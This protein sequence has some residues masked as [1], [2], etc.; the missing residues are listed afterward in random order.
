MLRW[1]RQKTLIILLILFNG[2]ALNNLSAAECNTSVAKVI[3]IQGS[4]DKRSA[5]KSSQAKY[6]STVKLNDSLCPDDMLRVNKNSRAAIL[7]SND[8]LLRLNQNTTITLA[9]INND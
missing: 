4:V 2:L 5:P 9:N 6:W 1:N 8:T 3:S 7:L